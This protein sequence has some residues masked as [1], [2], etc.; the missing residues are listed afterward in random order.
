MATRP[1][2]DKG[3]QRTPKS[4]RRVKLILGS[5]PIR[6]QARIGKIPTLSHSPLPKRNAN[7]VGVGVGLAVSPGA[8]AGKAA[9]RAIRRRPGLREGDLGVYRSA[10]VKK[11]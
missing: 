1:N 11:Q 8:A 2:R 7:G 9:T 3:P 6:V 5:D 4:H 10:I